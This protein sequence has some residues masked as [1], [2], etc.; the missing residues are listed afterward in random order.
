MDY[1][2]FKEKFVEDIK[3]R[4]YEQ[5]VEVNVSLNKVDKLNESY[6]AINITPEGSNIGMN[7]S[8]D[9]FFDAFEN[10]ASYDEVI[11]KA[12]EV[13]N[14]GLDDRPDFD[15]DS[16]MD[17]SVMKEKL[18]T[19]VV[20][21][22]VNKELL[23][24]IPHKNIEDMAVV[25]RF[26][27]KSDDDGR[28]SILVTNLILEKM[29]ITAEQLHKDAMENAPKLKPVEIRGMSEVIAEM[30][31]PEKA[32]T[33]GI[34]PLEP[35]EEKIFVASVP[36]KVHGAGVIAYQDFMEKAAE[37]AGGDF[38]ILP[39]SLHE[40]LIVPD[41]GEVDLKTLEA[42]VK[43]VNATQVSP[44]DKLTDSVYHYDTKEKIFEL[45][46]KF[47]RRSIEKDKTKDKDKKPSVL[48]DLKAKKEEVAKAPKKEQINRS[49]KSKGGEA[50]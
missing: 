24:N 40:L 47:V 46:E 23:E 28:A 9:K 45:G 20:S 12:M 38:Y 48:E 26:I 11:D 31:G 21:A 49:D 35:E 32:Q 39:S 22:E 13:I 34:V 5:G 43:D 42:M 4:L 50:I 16:L 37:R 30:M 14:K 19:E 18:V 8:I 33:M 41:N 3:N 17:Y 29:G 36:D 7:V 10:G 15:L 44:E 25:Y 6:E 1:E 27:L 2:N